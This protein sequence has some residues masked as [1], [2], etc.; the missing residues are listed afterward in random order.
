M[1]RKTVSMEV[2]CCWYVIRMCSLLLSQRRART[3][4]ATC[5][6]AF[7]WSWFRYSV[8]WEP[9]HSCVTFARVSAKVLQI[10]I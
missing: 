1:S 7:T 8:N 2:Y 10:H 4:S 3:P 5:R 6:A 9:T